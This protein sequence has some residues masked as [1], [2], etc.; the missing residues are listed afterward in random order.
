[1]MKTTIACIA[2]FLIAHTSVYYSQAGEVVR[3]DDAWAGDQNTGYGSIP[4]EQIIGKLREAEIPL[5]QGDT[6]KI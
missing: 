3:T 6:F 4:T 2:A 5:G 1:M